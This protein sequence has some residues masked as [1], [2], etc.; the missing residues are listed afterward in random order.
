MRYSKRSAPL[1]KVRSCPF[2]GTES[3]ETLTL[4]SLGVSAL[5][6]SEATVGA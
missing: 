5:H 3:S 1:V 2:S 4:R 6:V